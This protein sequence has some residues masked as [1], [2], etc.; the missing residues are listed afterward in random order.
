MTEFVL[1]VGCGSMPRGD[2]NT[3]VRVST[4]Y[5]PNFVRA[6][7]EFLP[8]RRE[9][10]DRVV[11][12][13]TIEHVPHPEL[14]FSELAR[15]S[16]SVVEIAFPHRLGDDKSLWRASNMP[17]LHRF[18]V[19]WFVVLARKLGLLYQNDLIGYRHLPFVSNTVNQYLGFVVRLPAQI[20]LTFR[21]PR[22]N[23]MMVKVTK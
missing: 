6:S 14:F 20:T 19:S 9:V 13:N 10:F 23:N 17:H 8:F 22:L 3:D 11:S 4:M 5:V 7:G 21:K 16:K 2:V 12:I 18:N 1:D 15:V